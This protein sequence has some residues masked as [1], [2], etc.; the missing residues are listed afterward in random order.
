MGWF[1]AKAEKE[2]GVSLARLYIEKAQ[3]DRT[4]KERKFAA[5]KHSDLLARM[6]LQLDKYRSEHKL[7]IYK[8]AQLGNSFKWTL[9]EAGFDPDYVDEVTNWLMLKL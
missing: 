8:T 6:S 5:E 2:F 4:K 1:N 3:S 7:N 9:K